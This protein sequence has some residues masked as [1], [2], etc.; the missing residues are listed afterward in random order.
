MRRSRK[1]GFKTELKEFNCFKEACICLRYVEG[2]ELTEEL[3]NSPFVDLYA[4][5]Y[6]DSS[7]EPGDLE[8][9]LWLETTPDSLELGVLADK[10]PP[11]HGNSLLRYNGMKGMIQSLNITTQPY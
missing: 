6:K 11:T 4:K 10:I 5:V 1:K 7:K 9:K 3:K 2:D 8:Q